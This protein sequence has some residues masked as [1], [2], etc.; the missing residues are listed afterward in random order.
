MFH[1][2]FGFAM[3]Y[4]HQNVCLLFPFLSFFFFL[5]FFNFL[6]KQ[7]NVSVKVNGEYLFNELEPD[8]KYVAQVRCAYA[9]HFWKWSEPIS[10]K[11]NT[12]EAGMFSSLVSNSRI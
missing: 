8:T 4:A 11:F 5:I 1:V 12:P 9:D 2:W 3:K 6:F 7:Q 10:Q